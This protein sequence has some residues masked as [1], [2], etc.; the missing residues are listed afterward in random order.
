MR[1]RDIFIGLIV[2]AILVGGVL[3][4][5][6]SRIDRQK[7]LTITPTVEEKISETFNGL[8]VPKDVEKVELNDTSGGDGFGIATRD[9]VLVDL[10][11]LEG[12]YFY[13]VWVE[14]NGALTSLGK[15]QMA[16]GGYLFE[17]RIDGDGVVVSKEKVFDN[18]V[19]MKLLEGAF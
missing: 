9:M 6:K 7:E 8:E 5:R 3:W 1:T 14:N 12:G 2:I 17:G 10:P 16:K 11:D 15:M 19:E 13:Q 4:L 18:K